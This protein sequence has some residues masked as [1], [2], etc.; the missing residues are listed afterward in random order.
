MN[1]FFY[2]ANDL[3]NDL[4]IYN[5]TSSNLD[6]PFPTDK[7]ADD[8]FGGFEN[9]VFYDYLKLFTIIIFFIFCYKI[10]SIFFNK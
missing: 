5:E 6:V 8:I 4:N 1:D 9:I 2:N 7:F 3:N 10:F